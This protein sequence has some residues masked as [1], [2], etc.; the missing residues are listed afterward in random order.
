MICI[1]VNYSFNLM[2]KSMVMEDQKLMIVIAKIA[3]ETH[4]KLEQNKKDFIRKFI[5]TKPLPYRIWYYLS[6]YYNS[7]IRFLKS[8]I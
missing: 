7:F 5:M 1:L 4:L 3:L 6:E 2:G 8:M